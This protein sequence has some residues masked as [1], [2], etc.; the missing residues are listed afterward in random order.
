[1][2]KINYTWR[3]PLALQCDRLMREI[4]TEVRL[5][6]EQLITEGMA[7]MRE[8]LTAYLEDEF[9]RS[10]EKL[11]ADNG[12]SLTSSVDQWV[13]G[14]IDPGSVSGLPLPARITRRRW[15]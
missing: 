6:S 12:R 13:P 14:R 9:G 2:R 7:N 1:M 10:R 11:R 3:E 15:A 5:S 4:R 8:L